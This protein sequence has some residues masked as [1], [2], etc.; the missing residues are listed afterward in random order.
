MKE[1]ARLR[2]REGRGWLFLDT[3]TNGTDTA[4]RWQS[5][6]ICVISSVDFVP[7]PRHWKYHL[8]VHIEGEALR[9]PSPQAL[10]TVCEAFNVPADV[11]QEPGRN[12]RIVHLYARVP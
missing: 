3:I 8:S 11:E 2:P 7:V 12:P 5:G 9:P 6:P 4:D 10:Q 1:P